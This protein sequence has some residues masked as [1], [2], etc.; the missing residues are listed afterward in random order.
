MS[1][2]EPILGSV[3]M[4]V[5]T[6][7]KPDS[8]MMPEKTVETEEVQVMTESHTWDAYTAEGA[9]YLVE[10]RDNPEAQLAAT[11]LMA[12]D[13]R[14]YN[15]YD[16]E[17]IK[18]I[19]FTAVADKLNLDQETREMMVKK[20]TDLVV[21]MSKLPLIIKDYRDIEKNKGSV[22]GQTDEEIEENM[23]ELK[24]L[25]IQTSDDA[26]VLYRELMLPVRTAVLNSENMSEDYKKQA[27][28]GINHDNG[29]LLEPERQLLK[30]YYPRANEQ[31]RS[32][33][34]NTV[35]SYMTTDIRAFD[36]VPV[37][38]LM[39]QKILKKNIV[40][41]LVWNNPKVTSE[42]VEKKVAAIFFPEEDPKKVSK[43]WETLK[44]V[45]PLEI[46][47]V[48]TP[49][50]HCALMNMEI[51]KGFVDN[52][53]EL[54]PVVDMLSDYGFQ[55][56]LVT[57]DMV[58]QVYPEYINELKELGKELPE[59][60]QQLDSIRKI[61]P[62]YEYNPEIKLID[63]PYLESLVEVNP[64][65]LALEYVFHKNDVGIQWDLDQYTNTFNSL[66]A[67]VPEKWRSGLLTTYINRLSV[68]GDMS[69]NLKLSRTA[70]LEADKW[71]FDSSLTV[72][73]IAVF[74][75]R[76][77]E[78]SLQAKNDNT[79][80][81]YEFCKQYADKIPLWNDESKKFDKFEKDQIW[82]E[83]VLS[84]SDIY[85]HQ[86]IN[87]DTKDV[88]K[89][90]KEDLAYASEAIF[91]MSDPQIKDQAISNLIYALTD[92]ELGDLEKAQ[93]YVDMMQEGTLKQDAQTEVL[94]E[95]ERLNRG[96]S[97]TWKKMEKLGRTAVA[98]KS[99]LQRSLGYESAD[100]GDI[101]SPRYTKEKVEKLREEINRIED[102]FCITVNITWK[103][104]L[105]AL[106]R[107]RL[108]SIWENK[109]EMDDRMDA[110]DILG[111]DYS[112][113]RNRVEKM[114]GNRSKGGIRDPHP[115]YG[116]AFTPNG[117]DEFYGGAGGSYGECFVVLKTD[118]IKNRTSFCYDDS[119][120]VY[121]KWLLDWEGG[122]SAKA[123][124]NLEGVD[125]ASRHGYVEAQ[126]LGGVSLDDIESINIPSNATTQ[127]N[128][129][130]WYAETQDIEADL[131]KL[132]QRFPGLK[133]N[134]IEVPEK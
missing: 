61:L 63:R 22:Y 24:N 41:A 112:Q 21:K 46:V 129:K 64:F 97:T 119:F 116:A 11:M 62:E 128:K 108:I 88:I 106:D 35:T 15:K 111:Y 114:L 49:L 19:D 126:I 96:E 84:T 87:N 50:E 5:V 27:I 117:R 74:G 43:C 68:I 25:E 110:K 30:D 28:R 23:D 82:R 122:I 130:G 33:I 12:N 123:I 60:K 121:S 29:P 57:P 48:S 109:A 65:S 78:A 125:K 45:V 51:F 131:E 132:K 4:D 8:T 34:I 14:V 75:R 98:N 16:L 32:V 52:A 94:L 86:L 79:K 99:A 44:K 37:E 38:D 103:N 20:R 1:D 76:F 31:E 26:K 10:Q 39:E 134:I 70:V 71:V 69:S 17:V 118:K 42:V 73:N 113:K 93:F 105:S 36:I 56:R 107:G 115:I 81:V 72:N 95:L 59:L 101:G 80:M 83:F 66:V 47:S 92:E 55:Y 67:V 2:G 7:K 91:Q 120:G 53:E 18:A 40:F 54:L 58:N 85:R 89:K 102:N 3:P 104:L 9:R 6:G 100:A 133:I 77:F 124:H 13:C 127:E 90:S